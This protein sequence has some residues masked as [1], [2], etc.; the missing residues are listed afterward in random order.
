[1]GGLAAHSCS[2]STHLRPPHP[3][4][5]VATAT[6]TLL[7]LRLLPLPLLL[8]LLRRRVHRHRGQVLLLPGHA[9]GGAARARYRGR[10]PHRPHQDHQA[11]QRAVDARGCP[12]PLLWCLCMGH[13]PLQGHASHASWCPCMGCS[14]TRR[15]PE[16]VRM[17]V[18][19][20]RIPLCDPALGSVSWRPRPHLLPRH[21]HPATH[22][23]RRPPPPTHMRPL[24]PCTLTLTPNPDPDPDPL[25][26]AEQDHG[27]AGLPPAPA[28]H[29]AGQASGL[30]RRR[31]ISE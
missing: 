23:M 13:H 14:C 30:Q 3:R 17:H 19:V 29:H 28:L 22:A 5:Y 18:R 16:H 9:A 25:P 6:A 12:F 7:L 4:C 26:P 2:S 15:E 11:A 8:L 20:P 24:R 10:R 27:Q 21:Q 1:M 31:R